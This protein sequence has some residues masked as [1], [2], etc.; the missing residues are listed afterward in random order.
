MRG[1]WG[2][3]GVVLFFA[4]ILWFVTEVIKIDH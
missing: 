3:V 2:W 1:K 4:L